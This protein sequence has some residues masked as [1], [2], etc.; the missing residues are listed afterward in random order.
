MKKNY[1]LVAILFAVTAL[2]VYSCNGAGYGSSYVAPGGPTGPTPTTGATDSISISG[3]Q[4]VPDIDTVHVGV[5]V[6]WKNN[7]PYNHTVTS[8]D[9]TTFS[10]GNIAPGGIFTF[11]PASTGTFTYSDGDYSTT[12]GKLVVKP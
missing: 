9:G 12:K 7:D 5:L 2:L 10:S 4:Y 8:D 6:K 11:T 3:L 1:F